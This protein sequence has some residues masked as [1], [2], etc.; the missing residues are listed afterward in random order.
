MYQTFI[1]YNFFYFIY[2]GVRRRNIYQC[3]IKLHYVLFSQNHEVA[4]SEKIKL[5]IYKDCFDPHMIFLL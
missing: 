2:V 1:T 3:F 5:D 4:Y